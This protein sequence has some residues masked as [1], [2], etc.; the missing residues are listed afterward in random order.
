MRCTFLLIAGFFVLF[1][2]SVPNNITSATSIANF[3][4]DDLALHADLILV[5]TVKSE[6]FDFRPFDE[7]PLIDT[8]MIQPEEW[9][10]NNHDIDSDVE[11]RYYGKWA[12]L[13]DDIRARGSGIAGFQ[14]EF[15]VGEKVLLF[16]VKEEPDMYMGGGY[17][18]FGFQG[19]Y[20]INH[21]KDMAENHVSE[22]NISIDEIRKIISTKIIQI[23]KDISSDKVLIKRTMNSI[24]DMYL[25]QYLDTE[26]FISREKND[27]SINYKTYFD[28]PTQHDPT[29]TDKTPFLL[30]KI[31]LD[32][33]GLRD[34]QYLEC[35]NGDESTVIEKSGHIRDSLENQSCLKSIS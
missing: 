1:S 8:V 14:P 31:L 23:Q 34:S 13:A 9:L 6:W 4:H 18:S 32:K 17:Y 3:S 12:K 33:N 7:M 15:N 2:I 35:W 20:T 27:F 26:V 30:L 11:V 10:K 29:R 22:K 16:L 5:G 25:K 21:E 24:T 19:K 28:S